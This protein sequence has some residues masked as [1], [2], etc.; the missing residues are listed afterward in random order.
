MARAAPQSG[1]E[2]ENLHLSGGLL[3]GGHLTLSLFLE[4]P[5][6]QAQVS[7][8]S[9]ALLLQLGEARAQVLQG[10]VCSA[11]AGRPAPSCDAP[12]A[13][14]WLTARRLGLFSD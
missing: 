2:P 8:A 9:P 13:I 6:L 10:V 1:S 4:S 7:R 12:V 14:R 5:L 3:T 11:L